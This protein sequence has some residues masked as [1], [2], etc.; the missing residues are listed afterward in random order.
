MDTSLNRRPGLL[1]T[2]IVILWIQGA[3]SVVCGLFGLASGFGG[4]VYAG[5][6]EEP[7]PDEVAASRL[8][9]GL[10]FAAV[11]AGIAIVLMTDAVA[12]A[13]RQPGPYVMLLVVESLIGL[14]GVPMIIM[15]GTGLIQV[16]LA[17]LVMVGV[18]SKRSKDWLAG[19]PRPV[20]DERA[21]APPPAAGPENEPR[22]QE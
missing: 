6:P 8:V 13:R 9:A 17:V 20:A 1:T 11:F 22:P 7:V 15:F 3:S 4:G 5:M 19:E 12:L 2:A 10:L 14:V 16:P 21:P 18:L